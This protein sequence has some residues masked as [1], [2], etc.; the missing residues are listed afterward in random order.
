VVCPSQARA[1]KLTL[2]VYSGLIF[3]TWPPRTSQCLLPV[4]NSLLILTEH[5][6]GLDYRQLSLRLDKD[7]DSSKRMTATK[8]ERIIAP[9]VDKMPMIQKGVQ[10]LSNAPAVQNIIKAMSNT[11]IIEYAL[12]V[13]DH[14]S[15]LGKAIPLSCLQPFSCFFLTSPLQTAP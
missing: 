13:L 6:R 8:A 2:R 7:L 5:S 14:V 15:N 1:I 4:F 3:E 10:G 12:H 9:V 11:P